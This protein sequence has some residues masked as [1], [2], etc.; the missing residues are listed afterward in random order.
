M[1]DFIKTQAKLRLEGNPMD[2]SSNEILGIQY[3]AMA[4]GSHIKKEVVL[5]E[6]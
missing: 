5:T 3:S 6:E 1:E 2:Q 4:D